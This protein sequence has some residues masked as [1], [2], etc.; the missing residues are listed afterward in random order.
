MCLRATCNQYTYTGGTNGVNCSDGTTSGI[1]KT[2]VDGQW[3]VT[4]TA[5]SGTANISTTKVVAPSGDYVVDTTATVPPSPTAFVIPQMSTIASLS[6]SN[7]GSLL[8]SK[9]SCYNGYHPT[10]PLSCASP[11]GAPSFPIN[12]IDM[13]TYVPGVTKPALTVTL[14]DGY[15]RVTDT[16]TYD[17]GGTVGASGYDTDVQTGY[18]SWNGSS[19]SNISNTDGYGTYYLLDRVCFKKTVVSGGTVSSYFTYGASG[20]SFGELVT[21]QD[22]V[23]GVLTTTDTRTYDNL[24]RVLTSTGPNGE[25]TTTSYTQCSGQELSSV[26]VKTNSSGG[27]LIRSYSGYDCVGE[28]ATILTDSNTNNSSINFGSDPYW[29]PAST[30]DAAGVVTNYQYFTAAGYNGPAVDVQTTIVSGSS[31]AETKTRFDQSGRTF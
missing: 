15:S 7:G 29:R 11:S 14:L 31:S 1:N 10:S 5:Y 23:G 19:C 16:K 30:T 6:Y 24:G 4:H 26:T 3:T 2:T 17:F 20:N 8:A 21:R 18:G 9:Y 13:W 12:E 28:K 22:T 27:T 25:T